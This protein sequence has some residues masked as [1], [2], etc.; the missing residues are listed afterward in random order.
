MNKY[1]N[2]CIEEAIKG[3]LDNDG[4]PFGALVVKEGKIV[5]IG[6]NNVISQN[7]PI[8]HGE[9]VAIQDACKNLNTFDLTGCEL[10]TSAYP[11]MM[12][13][14]AIMWSNIKKVYY[15]CS[16]EDTNNIGFRDE[17]MYEWLKNKDENILKFEQVDREEALKAFEVWTNKTNKKQY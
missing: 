12:C 8:L 16:V 10:Y 2:I 17:F 1:M 5:G 9:I 6:H 15:G 4:G 14:G 13:C 11:C 3:V 7:N